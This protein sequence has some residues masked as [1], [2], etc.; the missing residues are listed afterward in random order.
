M[1]IRGFFCILGRLQFKEDEIMAVNLSYVEKV[2]RAI[3]EVVELK[4]E[5][6]SA[7]LAILMVAEKYELKPSTLDMVFSSSKEKHE[8]WQDVTTLIEHERDRLRRLSKN[9]LPIIIG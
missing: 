2:E 4:L 5:M 1:D 7:D 3:S 6:Q 8:K 9:Y